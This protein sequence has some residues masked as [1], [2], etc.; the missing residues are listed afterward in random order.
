MVGFGRQK[1]A[2][3]INWTLLVIDHLSPYF[4]N[5]D[6]ENG[7]ETSVIPVPEAQNSHPCEVW[8]NDPVSTP[9]PLPV[10][11]ANETPARALQRRGEGQDSLE[12][13]SCQQR[14]TLE[15]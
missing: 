11:V 5:F 1:A 6:R 8:I 9:E 12:A 14:C 13:I 7:K 2:A 10:E 3:A 4:L 15:K